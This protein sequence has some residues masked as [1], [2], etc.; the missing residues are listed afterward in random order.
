VYA[1]RE[2][3]EIDT[4]TPPRRDTRMAR[5]RSSDHL[6]AHEANDSGMTKVARVALND[7]AYENV[8]GTSRVGRKSASA[9]RW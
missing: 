2:S 1:P 7:P 4:L 5:S 9:G 3:A 8:A 6:Q